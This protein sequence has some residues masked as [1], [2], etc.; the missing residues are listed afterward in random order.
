M[1]A[2]GHLDSNVGGLVLWKSFLNVEAMIV[3][4]IHSGKS[5]STDQEN[6]GFR[7]YLTVYWSCYC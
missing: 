5:G 1:E 4:C 2:V 3:L 7:R 6:K